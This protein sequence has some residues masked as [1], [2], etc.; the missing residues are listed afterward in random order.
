[1]TTTRYDHLIKPLGIGRKKTAT[2]GQ[3]RYT[4]ASSQAA[5]SHGAWLNGRDHLEGLHLSFAWEYHDGLG[6][7]NNEEAPHVHPY[8]EVQFFVGLDTANVNYLGADIECC[9]GEE[10]E[11]Y[12]FSEPTVVV[13]PAG[14]PHG[15]VTTSRMYSPRGFGRYVVALGA[16]HQ[17]TR[18]E[19]K[20]GAPGKGGNYAHL[21]KPLKPGIVIER[22][23]LNTSGFAAERSA[24]SEETGSRNR[25]MPGPGNADHLSWMY[26][27][28]L[29]GLEVNMDWGFFSSPGLWHRGVGAHVHP[30]DEVLVFVGTDPSR[31]DQ[32]GAEIE[33]DLGKEHERHLIAEP[34]VVI[35]P[36]GLPHAPIVTRWVDRAF[37]FFSINLSGQP[38][39]TFID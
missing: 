9:L 8:P 26:G 30:V 33:I 15:P 29:E 7:W 24:A 16:A 32:L 6:N 10:M 2:G 17:S 31:G 39:M 25:M 3:K 28:D 1:M 4:E 35:C 22:K 21:V 5:I 37:A 36:A 20:T 14:V 11:P 27:S 19:M 34:S 38:E 12:T 23:K 18:L 13:V